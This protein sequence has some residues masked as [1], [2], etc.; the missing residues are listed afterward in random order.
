MQSLL[1]YCNCIGIVIAIVIVNVI[2]SLLLLLSQPLQGSLFTQC[3]HHTLSFWNDSE[4]SRDNDGIPKGIRVY[5]TSQ[6]CIM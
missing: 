5:M 4:G 6:P 2:T 3:V 1:L